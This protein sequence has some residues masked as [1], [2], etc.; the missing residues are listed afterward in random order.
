[1]KP[2]V[3]IA[4]LLAFV[5]CRLQQGGAGCSA[6]RSFR[7]SRPASPGCDGSC[8]SEVTLHEGTPAQSAPSQ[9]APEGQPLRH[10]D[11]AFARQRRH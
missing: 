2:S 4:A 1:M 7:H 3:L 9:S 8:R 10:S 11:P 5:S 6:R